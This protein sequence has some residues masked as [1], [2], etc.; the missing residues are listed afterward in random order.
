[1]CSVIIAFFVGSVCSLS[2]SN[3]F[4]DFSIYRLRRLQTYRQ[5]AFAISSGFIVKTVALYL[6]GLFLLT[7]VSDFIG[8][9]VNIDQSF[10]VGFMIFENVLYALMFLTRVGGQL[11]KL[12]K[13]LDE[14]KDEAKE[15]QHEN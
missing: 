5:L 8:R 7:S 13:M 3:Q 1:M 2:I 15:T 12:I 10:Y 11:S 9:M 6:M 14:N 4:S